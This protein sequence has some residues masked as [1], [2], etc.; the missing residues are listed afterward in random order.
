MC[1][2]VL[3]CILFHMIPQNISL[4]NSKFSGGKILGLTSVARYSWDS[5]WFD[6]GVYYLAPI[7]QHPSFLPAI[8]CLVMT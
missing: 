7:G 6:I 5:T 4:L 2:F 8:W 1:L 3:S